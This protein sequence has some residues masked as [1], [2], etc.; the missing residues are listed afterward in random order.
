MQ[1]K[2]KMCGGECGQMTYIWKRINGVGYCKQCNF[3]VSDKRKNQIK[4]KSKKMVEKDAIY[5]KLG[6]IFLE[7]NPICQ[8]KWSKCTGVATQIHHT[9]SRG[10]YHNDVDTWKAICA[11]CHHEIHFVS[12]GKAKLEN[13][14]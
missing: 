14:L 6:P 4:K 7:N 1:V 9:K 8:V 13:L 2:K 5:S 10:V 11:T 3:K 12:P